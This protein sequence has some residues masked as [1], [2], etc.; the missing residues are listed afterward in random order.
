MEELAILQE[1]KKDP[2]ITQKRLAEKLGKSERTIKTRTVAL[3]EKGYLVRENGKRNGH[4][5]VLVETP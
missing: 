3:Q 5:Q 4:W 2:K 1:I